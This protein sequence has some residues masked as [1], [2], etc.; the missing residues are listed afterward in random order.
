MLN[1]KSPDLIDRHVGSRVRMRRMMLDMSQTDLGQAFGVSYQQIQKYEKGLNRMG[2]SR[3][4]QA[5]NILGVSVSFF[6]ENLPGTQ[7]PGQ[8]APLPD[9]IDEF[10]SSYDGMRLI[11]AFMRLDNGGVRR[12][13]VTL[14][15]EISSR[16]G[17]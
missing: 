6:F 9:Y 4:Q 11:R 7:P 17:E 5:A 8:G 1:R 2:A 15:E 13:I 14:V 16:D 10:V 3:L 12:A